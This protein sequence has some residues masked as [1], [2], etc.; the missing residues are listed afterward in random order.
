MKGNSFKIVSA[1]LRLTISALVLG[2][3]L[4]TLVPSSA[5]ASAFGIAAGPACCRDKSSSHCRAHLNLKKRVV[6][7]EVMCGVGSPSKQEESSGEATEA[8]TDSTDDQNLRFTA[9]STKCNV[10]CSGC[11]VRTTH[12]LKR[13]TVVARAEPKSQ[14]IQLST[15]NIAQPILKSRFDLE[16][17]SSRGPPAKTS[18]HR[19]A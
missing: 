3:L 5:L 10:E 18:N 11:A 4:L 9:A 17:F 2:F 1:V 15:G 14:S 8:H 6:K 13:A 16:P 19:A 7:S 12:E